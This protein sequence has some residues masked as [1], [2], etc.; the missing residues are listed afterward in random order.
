MNGRDVT[1][2]TIKLY[3]GDLCL[4]FDW[5]I[6]IFSRKCINK[7]LKFDLS[8]VSFIIDQLAM[9]NTFIH[10]LPHGKASSLSTE[11]IVL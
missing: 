7:Y 1:K 9:C 10:D 2:I 11:A 6:Y 5:S 8:Y 3:L 4:T